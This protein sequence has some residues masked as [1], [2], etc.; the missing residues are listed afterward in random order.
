[1]HLFQRWVRCYLAFV[2]LVI[3]LPSSAYLQFTY[4]SPEL[5]LTAAYIEGY[6]WDISDI[7]LMPVGFS[8]SFKTP[9]QDLSRKPITHFFMDDF[10]F[11]FRSEHDLLYY[12]LR[13]SPA[14]YGRVSLNR[15]GEILGWNLMIAITEL[16]TPDTNMWFYRNVNHRVDIVSQGGTGLCN[17]DLFTNK[18]HPTT[19]HGQ[20]IQLVLLQF[21]YSNTNNVDSW[22]IEKIAVPEPRTMAFLLIGL[23]G[24]LWSRRAQVRV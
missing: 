5:P 3:S 6:P 4:T 12:P 23:L 13:L 18:F 14:S 9:E 8:I 24:L 10:T 22:T 16:I 11:S 15:E 20:W 17:C 19:W 7:G 2:S 1:M 21:D